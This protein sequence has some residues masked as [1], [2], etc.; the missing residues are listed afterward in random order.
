MYKDNSRHM[1]TSHQAYHSVARPTNHSSPTNHSYDRPHSTV[2]PVKSVEPANKHLS[3]CLTA[4]FG[5]IAAVGTALASLLGDE[6]TTK[7]G[8]TGHP[9]LLAADYS[10][11]HLDEYLGEV[12][13]SLP[14]L[15]AAAAAFLLGRLL[16]VLLL[17]VLLH[18]A[19]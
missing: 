3:H 2:P 5:A 8:E 15:N 17:L 9:T 1:V 6:T 10:K 14:N 18:H 11:E 16:L 19:H 7:C 4:S 13:L 12:G